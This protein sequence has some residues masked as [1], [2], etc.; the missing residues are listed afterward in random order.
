M[1]CELRTAK[2]HSVVLT[3]YGTASCQSEG[4]E[5]PTSRAP[6]TALYLPGTAHRA[7]YSLRLNPA[8]QREFDELP[9]QGKFYLLP[10][11]H[12][13]KLH[14]LTTSYIAD[15]LSKLLD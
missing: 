10:F 6:I 11:A 2:I 4:L 1:N 7:P 9:P 3:C 15:R 14:L 5:P 8:A 13:V 12:D